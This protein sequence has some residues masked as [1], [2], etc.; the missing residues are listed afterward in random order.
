MIFTQNKI[1]SF[2][3]ILKS[4]FLLFFLLIAFSIFAQKK[5][6]TGNEKSASKS[7]EEANFKDAL[8]EYLILIK[9][10]STNMTYN[11]RIGVC[12]LNTNI[13][14]T[15]AIPY[16]EFA[17]KQTKCEP[18]G[19]YEMGRAYQ[20]AYRFDDAIKAFKK[21]KE[22]SGGKLFYFIPT[23]RQ[24]EMCYQAQE[25]IKSPIDVTFENLGPEINSAYPDFRP[26]VPMDESFIVYT[27][28]RV[29]NLGNLMDYDGY[30]TSD[31][32][33]A[34]AAKNNKW[35]KAKSV[36]SLI[37][38][39]LVEETAG[40]SSD[41]NELYIFADNYDGI[42]DIFLS[43]RRG[44]NFQK[45]IKLG[46]NINTTEIEGCATI[47]PDKKTLY[48]SSD[49]ISS[50]GA[51]DIYMSNKLPNGEWGKPTNLGSTINTIYDED[52]PNLS[53]DGK[54][55]Y[56]AS[57]GHN[58]MGGYDVFESTWDN[59]TSTWGKP[60]NIGFP[61]NTPAD[62]FTMSL[63]ASGRHGYVAALRK[64][65][66]GDL[67][68]YKVTF[69]DVAPTYTIIRGTLL[70][71]DSLNIF[72]LRTNTNDTISRDTNSIK[73]IKEN[74]KVPANKKPFINKNKINIKESAKDSISKNN[75]NGQQ[76]KEKDYKIK[77]SV[78]DKI[79]KSLF[80]NYL[81]NKQTGNFL[82]ILPPGEYALTISG[83]GLITHTENFKII[84]KPTNSEL[85]KTI[86]L[87][88]AN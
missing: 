13:D 37:N 58:S 65:G 8:E 15:K 51:K 18:S 72:A 9:K 63:S 50:I 53:S 42:N 54:T 43:P 77:I 27:S 82:I 31:I 78:T 33:M 67:D 22:V 40:L 64:G 80:G 87:F 19:W 85:F 29:G 16:L 25:I 62:E 34:F 70:G 4:I 49:V 76:I 7:F 32:Y 36:G 74:K 52:C 1:F 68:I 59:Q 47:S 23:E 79:K 6:I 5:V 57:Q 69:N 24:I 88:P 55:L 73:S 81:P 14:K 56:F 66:Y 2:H 46:P 12:Y 3:S 41:G 28:K 30:M 60:V 86:Y 21:F 26:Y 11:F 45:S 48:F 35:T 71:N 10:D 61:L 20:M 39:T 17:V 44:K 84:E 38:S 83:E 75:I